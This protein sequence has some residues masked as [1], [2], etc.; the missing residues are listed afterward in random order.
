M[1]RYDRRLRGRS[2]CCGARQRTGG[3]ERLSDCQ[4]TDQRAYERGMKT[5]GTEGVCES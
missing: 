3:N 2:D 1:V 4:T 5:R